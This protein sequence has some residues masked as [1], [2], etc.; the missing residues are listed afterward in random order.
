MNIDKAESPQKSNITSAAG[1]AA[2]Q[3]SVQK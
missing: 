2:H 3:L 1:D